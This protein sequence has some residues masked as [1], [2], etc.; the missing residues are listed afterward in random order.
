MCLEDFMVYF[1][2]LTVCAVSLANQNSSINLTTNRT[3]ST[4][5]KFKID[6]E[7]DYFFSVYQ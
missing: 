7:G 2:I 3:H 6:T 4:M 1:D 5:V